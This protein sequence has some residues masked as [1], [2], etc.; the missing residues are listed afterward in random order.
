VRELSQTKSELLKQVAEIQKDEKSRFLK[1]KQY[2]QLKTLDKFLDG[3]ITHYAILDYRPEIIDSKEAK[4]EYGDGA[5][6]L[7]VLYGKSN[8]DLTWKLNRYYDGSGSYTEVIPCISYEEALEEMQKWIDSK[9]NDVPNNGV[10]QTAQKY[11]LRISEDYV[12]KYKI[13]EREVLDK[14]IKACQGKLDN[15]LEKRNKGDN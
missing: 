2:K 15:L 11:N 4:S 1:Y 9:M 12:N 10:I 14:S 5:L 3:K 6:R 8:G 13:Q 7:L